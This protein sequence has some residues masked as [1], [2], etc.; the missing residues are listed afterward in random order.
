MTDVSNRIF[1][2]YAWEDLA[3]IRQIIAETEHNLEAKISSDLGNDTTSDLNDSVNDRI[4]EAD[5]FIVFISESS[6]KSDY[7]RQCVVRASNLNKNIVPIEIDKQGIFSSKSPQEFKF[8][9]KTYNFNQPDSKAALFAQLKAAFGLSVEDGDSFGALIHIVTD[10]PVKILRYG[11]E[12][13]AARPNEDGRVR[14]AK[15]VHQL[16][17]ED[18]QDPALF[19]NKNIEIT[20]NDSE[21]FLELS[22]EQLLKQKQEQ[23]EHARFQEETRRRI[24]RERIERQARIEEEA[25]I[26]REKLAELQRQKAAQPSSTQ[27][28]P[29]PEKNKKSGCGCFLI[30]ILFAVFIAAIFFLAN[31]YSNDSSNDYYR[32]SEYEY[33]YET[34]EAVEEAT[35]EATEEAPAE[36]Y[37]NNNYNDYS[38]DYETPAYDSY[39]NYSGYSDGEYVPP[40]YW[41]GEF[42]DSESYY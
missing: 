21:Q 15:G 35:E 41:D 3:R 9:S 11:K 25:R 6:K 28:K 39:D 20:D 30:V 29:K 27:K 18:A 19:I 13:G 40:S 31:N 10:R 24:D 8:R 5:T 34:E 37:Y 2:C 38:G 17:I 4:A 42:D 12:I 7:V 32:T 26:E 14:L 36:D 33:P 1:F 23:E 16:R 22:M